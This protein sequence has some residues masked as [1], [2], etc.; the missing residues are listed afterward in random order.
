[1]P[2]PTD[3]ENLLAVAVR[4]VIWFKQSV[5]KFFSSNGV[6]PLVLKDV[7]RLQ[8]D[9][10][11]TIKIVHHV[12]GELDLLGDVGVVTAKRLLTSMNNWKDLGS[13]QAERR[14]QAASS[15]EAFRLAC[16]QF[17]VEQAF[18]ERQAREKR[19]R[20]AHESRM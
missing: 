16:A 9:N 12:L 18:E 3:I 6:P 17:L 14:G 1:M 2:I 10:V 8:A 5:Y 13:I 19:E 20:D 4:D 7:R 15:L 11:P